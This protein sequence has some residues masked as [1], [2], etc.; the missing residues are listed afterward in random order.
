MKNKI[1][2]DKIN[3]FYASY[4][5]RSLVEPDPLQ[6][7]YDYDSPSDREIVGLIASGLAYGNVKQILKSVGIVL[8]KL[9]KSPKRFIEQASKT[10]LLKTFAGFK[11]RFTTQEELAE[12]LYAIKKI[13]QTD[14]SL[15]KCFRKGEKDS[16]KTVFP[17]MDRFVRQFYNHISSDKNSL[18]PL[19]ARGSAC[20][21]LNLFLRWMVRKDQV[22]PGGWSGISPSKLIVPLDT[23]L[24]KISSLLGF[25]TRKSAD[26]RTA[27]EITE[28]FKEID[29]S[30]P[31]K[32]DF[33]LTR[34]GIRNDMDYSYIKDLYK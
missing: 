32:Y 10:D 23:H 33:A 4:N 2:I 14:G 9:G 27:L 15:E 18:L 7:L 1:D 11:H 3:S 31:V 24:H 26:M 13:L 28:K 17:A 29:I 22:D 21:R 6:Y 20:K 34:M 30:D 25:T 5:K 19:P 12:F 8:K 16:D